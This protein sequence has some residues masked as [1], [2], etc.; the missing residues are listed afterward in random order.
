[1]VTPLNRLYFSDEYGVYKI[2][3]EDLVGEGLNSTTSPD[4]FAAHR[5]L[6]TITSPSL[7]SNLVS[8]I[9]GNQIDGYNLLILSISN[10]TGSSIEYLWG[11]FPWGQFIWG[12]FI[13]GDGHGVMVVTNETEINPYADGYHCDKGQINNRGI[14]YL[15]NKTKN[16]IEAYYG[17]NIRSG[18]G[19]TPDYIY[20]GY[21]MP[22]LFSNDGNVGDILSLHIVNN[23]S[24]KL[25]EGTRLYVGQSIGMTIIDAFDKESSTGY[26]AGLDSAGSSI[27]C[28]IV[29]SGAT[30]EN[31]GGIVP[32]VY[33]IAT[34]EQY[35][36]IFVVTNDGAA[37]G[38]LT[39]IGMSDN[40]KIIFMD[41]DSGLVP[42]NDIR[43]ASKNK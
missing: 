33:D 37:H 41:E 28:G 5:F 1:M 34:D 19:R 40:R 14:L 8:S 38:G 3:L 27:F 12:G 32:N 35:Q 13:S 4:E 15:I 43:K 30:Y 39:Q 36:V 7:P 11:A 20:D 17:S 9:N 42:S 29:G 24:N 16:Q 2:D 6:S 21:S 10:A 31:I 23:D 18:V 25:S 26:S 22:A